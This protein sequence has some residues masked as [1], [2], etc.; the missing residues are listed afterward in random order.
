M[1][2]NLQLN[3][4]VSGNAKLAK[5]FVDEVQELPDD[6]DG[7]NLMLYYN[8]FAKYGDHV[9]TKCTVG[10]LIN[11]FIATD[12]DYWIKKSI[13]EIK[14]LSE[15]TFMVGVEASKKTRFKIDPKFTNSSRIRPYKYFGGAF[16]EFEDNWNPW[17]QSIQMK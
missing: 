9:F 17:S 6:I 7:E 8:F 1:L 2:Y 3:T 5:W 12:Y 11:Q 15:N 10:G 4:A 13:S 14:E 16:P